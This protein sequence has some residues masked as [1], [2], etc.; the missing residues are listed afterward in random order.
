MKLISADG[1]LQDRIALN[2]KAVRLLK[3]QDEPATLHAGTIVVCGGGHV[4]YTVAGSSYTLQEGDFCV[5]DR[6]IELFPEAGQSTLL[7]I[8][9]EDPAPHTPP[10]S[11]KLLF[12][13]I[14]EFWS[15]KVAAETTHYQIKLAKLH[16]EFVWH[17]HEATDELFVVWDGEL[18]MHFQSATVTMKPRTALSVP[19]GVEHCPEAEEIVCAI[20]VEP[21]GVVNTG[22]AGGSLTAPND[23]RI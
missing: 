18:M 4:S 22:K 15:P 12:A 14:K 3:V 1:T 5:L 2:S 6:S 11:L 13:S 23:V 19:R 8:E 9:L 16:G 10:R 7:I 17:N 20:L 21:K